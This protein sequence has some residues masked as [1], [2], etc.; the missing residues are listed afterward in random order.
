MEVA[1]EFGVSFEWHSRSEAIM[2]AMYYLFHQ[3]NPELLEYIDLIWT[4]E[5]Q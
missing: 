1:K 4:P 3:E 5:P 2:N